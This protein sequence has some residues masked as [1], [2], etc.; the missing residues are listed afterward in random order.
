MQAGQARKKVVITNTWLNSGYAGTHRTHMDVMDRAQNGNVNCF[1]S[2][3]ILI[4]SHKDDTST[5]KATSATVEGWLWDENETQVDTHVLPVG[6]LLP[7]AFRA[8]RP[9]NTTGRDIRIYGY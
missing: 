8:I 1:E 2:M 3:G 4:G 5:T 9:R 7:I 6:V